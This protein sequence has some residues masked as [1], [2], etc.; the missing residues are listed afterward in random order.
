M[1]REKGEGLIV[2]WIRSFLAVGLTAFTILNIVL[3]R[4]SLR[5]PRQDQRGG[6]SAAAV[7]I[8]VPIIGLLAVFASVLGAVVPDGLDRL[9]GREALLG[10][11]A[12]NSDLGCAVWPL[13]RVPTARV[14]NDIVDWSCSWNILG[15][16]TFR[17]RTVSG[18]YNP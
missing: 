7:L 1:T 17:G 13:T 18:Y 8:A 6:P 10:R 15:L 5:Q 16:P 9:E 12:V 11:S 3:L 14:K 2:P 4:R